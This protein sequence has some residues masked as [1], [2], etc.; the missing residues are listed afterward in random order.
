M[1]IISTMFII[2]Y[3]LQRNIVWICVW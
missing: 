1:L 2:Y 3:A